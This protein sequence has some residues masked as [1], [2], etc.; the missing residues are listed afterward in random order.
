ME[1]SGNR[2][3]APKT[4]AG[5]GEFSSA[6]LRLAIPSRS[7]YGRIASIVV[8]LVLLSSVA[9]GF[10][11]E[12]IGF[13]CDHL[14]YI[15]VIAACV[16][17]QRKG[18]VLAALLAVLLIASHWLLDIDILTSHDYLTAVMLFVVGVVVSVLSKKGR[19][20][21]Q[22]LEESER[23][24]REMMENVRLAV[25]VLDCQ[26]NITFI[27]DFLLTITH[28]RREDVLGRNWFDIFIPEENR[29]EIKQ[30]HRNNIVKKIEPVQYYENEILTGDG[31]RCL[32]A[33]NN[34]V[35]YDRR[36]NIVASNSIGEDITVRR[37]M[38]Q[39]Q[40]LNEKILTRLNQSGR[41]AELIYDILRIIKDFTG[42][43]AVG[44]RLRQG[45]D[46]PYFV[47]EGFSEGFVQKENYLCCRNPVTGEPECDS[48][49]RPYLECMCGNVLQGRTD[50]S[51]PFFTEAGSFCSNCT[52]ELLANTTEQDRQ[53]RT[54]NRC[55]A[56]G[57][58]SVALIPLRADRETVGLLQL[59]DKRT[60]CFSPDMIH[61]LER[62][63]AAVGVAMDKMRSEESLRAEKE[64]SD[65]LLDSSPD[66][67]LA[68]DRQCRITLWSTGMEQIS[69]V[70]RE[71]VVGKC[72][73]ESFPFLR[74][75]GEDRLYMDV[76]NG[77]KVVAGNRPF[78]KPQTGKEG[79][80]EAHYSPIHDELGHVTGGVGVV[81]DIT[82]RR[83]AEE[84]IERLAKFPSENPNPV[85]RIAR[86]G[87]IMYAN[88]AAPVLLNAWGCNNA[89]RLP[90]SYRQT[91]KEALYSGKSSDIESY[92]PCGRTFSVVLVPVCEGGYVNVYGLDIS[93]RKK[94]Q[95][96]VRR[97]RKEIAHASRLSAV[98]EMASNLAHELNQP[99]CA[100]M[101]HGEGCVR[102]LKAPSLD[103]ENL[104]RKMETIVKQ[105]EHAA[106]IIS[107]IRG[108]VGKGKLI[109]GAVD[110]NHIVREAVD[111]AAT[112]IRRSGIEVILELEEGV[113]HISGDSVQIEQ[114]LTNLIQNGL[115]AMD[116][117]PV[118]ERRL[119]V[120][121]MSAGDVIEVSV[122]D[123]GKGIAEKDV[124]DIFES[125]FT[126][127]ADGLGIG[128]SISRSIVESH[129]GRIS[130]TANP[131]GGVTFCFSLLRAG[132]G[133]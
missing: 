117:T 9:I 67:I 5:K 24:L 7:Q 8:V 64:F 124:D 23:R 74:E 56:E 132:R 52:T 89:Q 73:F 17:W 87:A 43:E 1:D 107:H 46:Y 102:M 62:L 133:R 15:P 40:L 33:W 106:K 57:Y 97:H 101:T 26:G 41:T 68:F 94:A 70:T 115:D 11:T 36:G 127:K 88:D 49:G 91:I 28:R 6:N 103:R 63:G 120:R 12:K 86:D 108:F 30:V 113:S 90:E 14:L 95:E 122:A 13:I 128:L 47:S 22:V 39:Y 123:T 84:K 60:N 76:L 129:G 54:R 71:R 59:N 29:E 18:L 83:Q 105:T 100:V 99:L 98:G 126:T 37:R 77:K 111:L 16:W 104:G 20:S 78:T 79:I 58:E 114:V 3:I 92:S 44:I 66:G 65:K 130:V 38:E 82:E 80:F 34:S 110:V 93:E 19:Q 116:E 85:L 10:H 121:S 118:D 72:V 69:G 96:E 31:R 32:V 125:F 81:C 55:N 109:R 21:M 4:S 25:V 27:N 131:G 112:E 50:P 119:T 53:A 35:M 75:I 45:D 2:T 48:Q 61:F 51:K 42:F